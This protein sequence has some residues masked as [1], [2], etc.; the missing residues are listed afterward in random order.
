[1]VGSIVRA[2]QWHRVYDRVYDRLYDRVYE[3]TTRSRMQEHALR[4]VDV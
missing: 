2:R 3:R 4:V 1:M